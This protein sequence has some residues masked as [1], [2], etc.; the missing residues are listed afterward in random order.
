MNVY[1]RMTAAGLSLCLAASLSVPSAHAARPQSAADALAELGILQGRDEGGLALEAGITRA[2]AATVLYRI[3]TGDV[4]GTR[5]T[6]PL[7]H[8]FSDVRVGEWYT[9]AIHW[10]VEQG[11]LSGH[12]D[13]S[14]GPQD[15]VTGMQM[16]AMLLRALGYDNG[17]DFT[18][19]DWEQDTTHYTG[20]TGLNHGVDMPLDGPASRNLV[21][22]L[23]HQALTDVAVA[24]DD[25]S[26]RST[27]QTLG[28]RYFGLDWEPELAELKPG[29]R[30]LLLDSTPHKQFN[31]YDELVVLL[32]GRV[33]RIR[34]DKGLVTQGMAA[35]GALYRA[36][37][38]RGGQL[39]RVSAVTERLEQMNWAGESI[40]SVVGGDW[41]D[42]GT[43]IVYAEGVSG[44]VPLADHCRIYQVEGGR[45]SPVRAR[46][47]SQASGWVAASDSRG[48]P[49]VVYLLPTP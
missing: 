15:P 3:T 7:S 38:L 24:R 14:F 37:T 40:L 41:N 13:G 30:F 45:V 29:A 48:Y 12:G 2:E 28:Q 27:G 32:E 49:T 21:A 9:A 20:L 19:P 43:G 10:C 18:G 8:P 5:L 22:Q 31:Q 6:A 35:N 34:T 23:T 33:V 11:W 36:D 16:S 25:G 42:T 47:I 1:K 17:N 39:S 44:Y 26:N 46:D 4:D